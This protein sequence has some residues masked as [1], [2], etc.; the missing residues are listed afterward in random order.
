MAP[1]ATAERDLARYYC[2]LSEA[3]ATLSLSKQE[4][5]I[6]WEAMQATWKAKGDGQPAP[7]DSLAAAVEDTAHRLL[8][9]SDVRQVNASGWILHQPLRVVG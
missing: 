7:F 3:L 6:V 9:Y 5:V 4:A 2:V 1:Y 8:G